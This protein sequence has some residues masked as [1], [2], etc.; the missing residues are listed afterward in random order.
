MRQCEVVAMV[1]DR[2]KRCESALTEA[3]KMAQRSGVCTGLVKSY[4]PTREDE[5]PQAPEHK[6]PQATVAGLVEKVREAIPSAWDTVL[7]QDVGNTKASAA[8]SVDGRAGVAGLSLPELPA[9][10]LI[11]L[12]KQVKDL[13]TFIE[14]L[15]TLEPGHAWTPDQGGTYRASPQQQARTRKIPRTLVKYEATKE[16]PAQTEVY[17]EDVQVGVWDTTQISGAM[18][19]NDKR[20]MV[21]RTTALLEAIRVAREQANSCIVEQQSVAD[22][23]LDFIFGG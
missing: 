1:Q 6:A 21:K 10:Y 9:T 18:P 17:A 11:Y 15:P 4:T 2:K 16:H 13:L 7:T 5:P 20:A 14:S 19:E 23:V 3:Y 8:I 12:E 22:S